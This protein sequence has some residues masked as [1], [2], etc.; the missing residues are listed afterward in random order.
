MEVGHVKLSP[1]FLYIYTHTHTHTEFELNKWGIGCEQ[2][3]YGMGDHA[4][5]ISGSSVVGSRKYT[6]NPGMVGQ[7]PSPTIFIFCGLG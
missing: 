7:M 1:T 2:D 6:S 5:N 3:S 4:S